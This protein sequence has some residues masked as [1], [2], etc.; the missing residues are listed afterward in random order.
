V[1]LPFVSKAPLPSLLA[2]LAAGAIS[3][4]VYTG[5]P[6][7]K[8]KA[9][10]DV[11]IS[12]TFGP[13][14]VSFAFLVQAGSTGWGPVLASLPITSHIEAIL[15][16]NNARDIEE[17]LS[18]GVKTVAAAIGERAS[19]GLYALL[20]FAPYAAVAGQAWQRSF[21]AALPM[22]SLPIGAKLVQRF[23]RKEMFDLPKR[24][25]KFQFMFGMLLVLG[26]LL[27]SPSLSSLVSKFL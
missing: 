1:P 18:N 24:T 5:G 26:V 12:S 4:F 14:L 15:H 2:H 25:A 22:L 23:R 27:P 9:L 7:L 13:L 21:F 19:F 10:G 3:A 20:L 8:Y 11:L 6:G 16:A 17:D